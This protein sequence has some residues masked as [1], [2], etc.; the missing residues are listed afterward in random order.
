MKHLCLI[1]IPVCLLLGSCSSPSPTAKNTVEKPA[2]EPVSG[3]FAFHQTYLT[4][5]TWAQDLEVLRVRNLALENIKA[6]PGK[7]AVWEIV[8]V[9]A[10]KAKTRPY[11]FSIIETSGI[12]EGVFAGLE[13]DWTGRDG[14]STAF[15]PAAFKVDSVDAW[16]TAVEK[17]EEYVKKNPDKPVTF[18]LE[19]TPRHPDP[20][21]RVFWGST[22]A[23]S[24]YS[25]FIDAT[26]GGFVERVR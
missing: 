15:L 6:E 22:V 10:S 16:K 26:T 5:R 21:W 25:I 11:T 2:P 9:S 7:A 14:Q 3:R 13:Q 17:G 24:E 19:K 8:F 4:A 23:T 18:L 1:L 12:H 20:T